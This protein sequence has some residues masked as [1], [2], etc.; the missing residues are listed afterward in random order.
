M[1]ALGL[2]TVGWT[3]SAYGMHLYGIVAFARYLLPTGLIGLFDLGVPDAA[4]RLVARADTRRDARELG[5]IVT[6]TL[7]AGTALGVLTGAALMASAGPLSTLLLPLS[8]AEAAQFRDILFWSG[9][10]TMPLMLGQA[11]E[12][13]LK[14]MNR[15]RALRLAEIAGG[16]LFAGAVWWLTGHGA[17]YVWVAYA[18]LATSVVRSVADLIWLVVLVS[19]RRWRPA[20]P[21]RAAVRALAESAWLLMQS[22]LASVT[23]AYLPSLLIGR[24]VGPAGVGTFDVLARIPRLIKVV[25]GVATQAL[26][27]PAAILDAK[28]DDRMLGRLGITATYVMLAAVAPPLIGL[29]LHTEVVLVR[30]LGAPFADLAP[31]LGVFLIWP[32]LL[33]TYQ[34]SNAVLTVRLAA[35]KPLNRANGLQVVAMLLLAVALTGVFAEK[36]FVLSIVV[37]E[38]L[39]LPYR[40]SVYCRHTASSVGEYWSAIGR[41]LWPAVPCAALVAAIRWMVPGDLAA[42]LLGFSAYCLAHWAALYA[43]GTAED[44]STVHRALAALPLSR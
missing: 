4:A 16:L 14:G 31:W 32:L 43:F 39:F 36:A 10:A 38:V 33:C 2:L 42:A 44:R 40:I 37:C 25:V 27:R 17:S 41:V 22:K 11:V 23:S 28:Q 21:G 6:A 3:V 8:A 13:V 29:G 26:L 18:F 19:H 9:A 15:F 20:R 12:G 7:L 5:E 24:L 35:L 34:S 1:G 30:W